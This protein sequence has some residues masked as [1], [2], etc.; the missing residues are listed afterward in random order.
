VVAVRG[1]FS[2][3]LVIFIAMFEAKALS[4]VAQGLVLRAKI[5]TPASKTMILV[6][7]VL[8]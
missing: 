3:I 2:G 5:E 7:Q 8:I 4:Q 1:A 6:G